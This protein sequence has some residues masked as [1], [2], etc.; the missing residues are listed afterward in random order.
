[1]SHLEKDILRNKKFKRGELKEEAR[2]EMEEMKEKKHHKKH[3]M[4]GKMKKGSEARKAKMTLR[5]HGRGEG[6]HM[7]SK[8]GHNRS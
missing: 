4:A 6:E 1:M 2:E 3:E 7:M 5:S 8:D